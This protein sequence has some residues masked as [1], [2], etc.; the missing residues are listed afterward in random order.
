MKSIVILGAG[1][2][3]TSLIDYLLKRAEK[4]DWHIVVA[5]M[6]LD[7]VR[8]KTGDHPRSRAVQ[9]DSR[10]PEKRRK[11]LKDAR[12]VISMLPPDLHDVVA[13][14]CLAYQCH[15][16]TASYLSAAMTGL[17]EE[18]KKRDLLFLTEMGL[19][20]GIDHMSA[21]SMIREIR[22]EGGQI[23]SFVSCTGGLISPESDDNPWH[24][25]ITWNPRNVI[26]AGQR[27]ARFRVDGMIKYLPYQ[28]L[29]R[30]FQL[31]R[32]SDYGQFEM[33]P[34]R[35]SL[36]YASIYGL[37]ATPTIIRGTLRH[38]GFCM[39]WDALVHLGLTDDQLIIEAGSF[40][41]YRDLL[42]AF[43]PYG[44]MS[45]D[46]KLRQRIGEVS[47]EVLHQLKWLLDDTAVPHKT[48]SMAELLQELIVNKW[49]LREDDR[50]MVVMH[51]EVTYRLDQKHMRRTSS[52]VHYGTNRMKTAMTDL[53]GLPL[54]IGTRLLLTGE[55]KLRG[56]YLPVAEA[57]YEPVLQ[58]LSGLGVGFR[59]QTEIL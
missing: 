10:D 38:D 4:H 11:L 22:Q 29:F 23:L 48:A 41:T 1:R 7:L 33:Y 5:D 17:G 26:L 3:A 27:T 16:L 19:D 21:M 57:I 52:M 58:E 31:I 25:K 46:R 14:D 2:S 18:A 28:Q 43:L 45:L 35:D 15:L 54:G 49:A 56:V 12:V 32:V 44:T 55:I 9:I 50:D 51:H 39:G 37:A 47:P 36:P 42:L 34:N 53:V 24:Y 59:E 8:Q 30:N 20:P 40:A 6:D 13:L